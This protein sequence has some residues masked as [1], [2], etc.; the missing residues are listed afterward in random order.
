MGVDH[1]PVLI[2]E[3][4]EHLAPEGSDR[5]L[6]DATVG[7][8]GHSAG[9]LQR[10]SN[11]RVIGIDADPTMIERA[12]ERLRPWEGRFDLRREWFDTYAV[13][14]RHE[15][16]D[17]ILAD[18]GVSMFHFAGSHRGFS[19]Q[20]H[21]PLDMRLNPDEDVTAEHIVNDTPEEELVNLIFRYGEERY[22]RRIAGTICAKRSEERITTS[23]ALADII[24]GAVPRDYRYGRIHPAT[25]TFQALRIVVNRELERIESFIP[26]AL[27]KLTTG[28][29][30]GIIA[31]HSLE[32]RIVKHSFRAAAQGG[33]YR[34]ITKKPITASDGEKRR[35]PASRSAKF[36]VIERLSGN[37]Q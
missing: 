23:S 3:V 25:R 30:L 8:G 31:F 13:S 21:G 16:A 19:Y 37:M 1:Q 4:L 34:L 29:R 26:A 2:S 11:I 32:D 20:E 15:P 5:L 18:L 27:E 10:F 6:F 28:G 35:N 36:R 33:H 12:N 14:T 17:R 24:R 7:A 9:F 22:S